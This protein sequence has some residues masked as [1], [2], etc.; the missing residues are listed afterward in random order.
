[1]EPRSRTND[2]PKNATSVNGVE[3]RTSLAQ[4]A[5]LLVRV[6][7]AGCAL[8]FGIIACDDVVR[9]DTE[10]PDTKKP[11]TPDTEEPAIDD[12]FVGDYHATSGNT[13]VG[14]KITR[15]RFT[16][17]TITGTGQANRRVDSVRR[18]G[19]P[20]NAMHAA[21]AEE[22]TIIVSGTVAASGSTVTATITE[23]T[24][25]GQALR[26]DELHRYASCSI[27]ATIG[28]GF[29]REAVTA[30]LD[31]LRVPTDAGV[32]GIEQEPQETSIFGTWDIDL[33]DP[34][35]GH[36]TDLI[37]LMIVVSSN[38]LIYSFGFPVCSLG[39]P[40]PPPLPLPAE[41]PGPGAPAPPP[42]PSQLLFDS[43]G[44]ILS[45]FIADEGAP[46]EFVVSLSPA[47]NET[48]TVDWA[49]ADPSGDYI[50]NAGLDYTAGRGTL[51]FLPGESRRTLT[52]MTIDDSAVEGFKYFQVQLT[53]AK[54]A[55]IGQEFEVGNIIDDED[56]RLCDTTDGH[57]DVED[58]DG[59]N[60]R[61]VFRNAEHRTGLAPNEQV[62]AI[63]TS[64]IRDLLRDVNLSF[65]VVRG[66][67]GDVAHFRFEGWVF[68]ALAADADGNSEYLGYRQ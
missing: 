47:A 15:D 23:V 8:T 1:M 43:S 4:R 58:I 41:E 14:L 53:N 22:E 27:T 26:G 11:G 36:T 35:S 66:P 49:T 13:V 55:Y 20:G 64:N 54:G 32:S 17:L 30:I 21:T 5:A 45:S 62:E 59:T 42:P 56:D 34:I 61:L 10:N 39:P 37:K 65:V 40:P 50:A 29:A 6:A 28:A 46:I 57:Y 33:R 25:N 52:V 19:A 16:A 3:C 68:A 2:T 48:V 9:P 12:S 7:A 18:T 31:C 44:L 51:T 67:T 24:R 63:D 38:D 60:I